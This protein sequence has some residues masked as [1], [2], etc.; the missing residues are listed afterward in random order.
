M[1]VD[2]KVWG[3]DYTYAKSISSTCFDEKTSLYVTSGMQ[4]DIY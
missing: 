3:L 1:R 4:K 2:L